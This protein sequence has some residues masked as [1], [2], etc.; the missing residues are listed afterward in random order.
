[1]ANSIILFHFEQSEIR[2][3]DG[4]PIANDVAA[5]LGYKDPANAVN[6]LV[7]PKNKG[8]C[9]LQTPGGVQEATV[10]EEGGIYQLIFNSKLEG[11]EKFQDWVFDEVLPSIR[12][13]GSYSVESDRQEL[14]RKFLPT[15]SLKQIAECSKTL[16]AAGV[17][18]LYIERLSLASVRK[19]Y[20]ELLPE[21]PKPLELASLPTANAL[22]TPTDIAAE[23]GWMCK[24]N[25]KSGDA[26]RVNS[27]LET[28]GYQS[29]ISGTWSAT[30]KAIDA[31]LCD[32]KP[33]ETG[34]RTQKD[35]LLWSANVISIL[36]EH[37]LA[38][39]T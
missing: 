1:M 34:S 13:T 35:Q 36:Q 29:K 18:P 30:Q 20:P 33:V 4:K 17:S 19:Y 11:A 7:K 12:K 10:L 22:L 39:L 38:S 26:R 28:L 8:V 27:T 9:D 37:S 3:A 6:R 25:V 23:L 15:P 24:S 5:A 31:N 21:E 16:K 32:R 14:E 2:F